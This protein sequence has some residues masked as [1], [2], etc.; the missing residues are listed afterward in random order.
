A[1]WLLW[2]SSLPAYHLPHL[3]EAALFPPHALHRA[4]HYSGVERL[5]WLGKTITQLVVLGVFVR[6]GV[7]WMRESAAGPIGTGMLLGMIGFAFVWAAELPL[8]VLTVWWRHRYG[9]PAA[10]STPRSPTGSRSGRSSCCSASRS[11]S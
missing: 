9:S 8:A 1:A 4:Q 6:Y 3:D 7:R 11:R 5:F 10:T 2:R